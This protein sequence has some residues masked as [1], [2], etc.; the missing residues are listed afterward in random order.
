MN[1]QLLDAAEARKLS[2]A[3]I[4]ADDEV[5]FEEIAICIVS[6]INKGS[7]EI[8]FYENLRP[9]IIKNLKAK[10]YKVEDA[11]NQRDGSQF[12]ISW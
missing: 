8:W 4:S 7:T 10:G 11:T 6:A 1:G 9:N 5:Q 12:K 2:E 3:A